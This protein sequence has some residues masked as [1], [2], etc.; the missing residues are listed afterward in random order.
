MKIILIDEVNCMLDGFDEEAISYVIEATKLP[1]KGA[2][3]SA[4]YRSKNWDGKESFMLPSGLFF[5][6][7]MDDVL[8]A[9]DS[10][11]IDLDEIAVVDERKEV[12]HTDFE[13]VIDKD[14]FSEFGWELRNHQVTGINAAIKEQRG[15]IEVGTAG[16][17]SATMAGICKVF[18]PFYRSITVTG[19]ETLVN[20]LGNT[21]AS[22]GLDVFKLK[23]SV[24]KESDR[25]SA[26][27]N[28]RHIITTPKLLMNLPEAAFEDPFQRVFLNDETHI[29]GDEMANFIRTQ[30][31]DCPIRIGLTGTLPDTKRDNIQKRM[32]ILYHI[33]GHPLI[34][35]GVAELKEKEYVSN[36]DVEVVKVDDHIGKEKKAIAGKLYSWE[37]EAAHYDKCQERLETIASFI[38]K[39]AMGKNTLILT[40]AKFGKALA[41][42]LGCDFIDKDVK[43]SVRESYFKEF[44]ER[45]DMTLVA[46][47]DTVGTGT[48]IPRIFHEVLIDVGKN[49]THIAQGIGRGIRRDGDINYLKVYDIYSDTHYAKKH[50]TERKKFYKEK[51]YDFKMVDY[52]L[53]T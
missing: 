44:D 50:L 38:R 2:F 22:F 45:D 51:G 3:T 13:L 39:K 19:S 9:L 33:G 7:M 15:I 23:A 11:G 25:I 26:M 1:V 10:F 49:V 14:H 6:E 16:G 31:A 28:H 32:K 52:G 42:V 48:D 27:M 36:F 41:E 35:V 37:M 24:K 12:L 53:K 17:K 4:A 5:S 47:F 29:F 8:I 20:Q 34:E 30:L 46:T 18:D 21:Y 40:R 43:T